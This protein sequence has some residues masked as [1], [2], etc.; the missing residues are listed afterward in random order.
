LNINRFKH[1]GYYHSTNN[2][3][4]N[5]NCIYQI[6][7]FFNRKH[8]KLL[9]NII[10]FQKKISTGKGFLI[11][12]FDYKYFKNRVNIN[13][14]IENAKIKKIITSYSKDLKFTN[15]ALFYTPDNKSIMK[16]QKFHFDHNEPFHQLKVFILLNKIN[17]NSGPFTFIDA[18]KSKVFLCSKKNKFDDDEIFNSIGSNNLN[19]FTGNIA[20]IIFIDTARCLHY[21]ARNNLNKRLMLMLKYEKE[22]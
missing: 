14:I 5:D 22:N 7:N 19:L 3:F 1:F 11:D 2:F 15:S 4:T 8:I 12:L 18:K 20:D 17:S 16:S 10:K 9:L 21:G 6:A 13:K